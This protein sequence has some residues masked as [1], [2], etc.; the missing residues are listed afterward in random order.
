MP[1]DKPKLLKYDLGCGNNLG[2]GQKGFIGIDITK[3]GTKA[4]I[5]YDLLKFPWLFAKDDSVDEIFCSHF[6]EHI[7]HGN[8]SQDPFFEFFNETYRIL[9]PNAIARFVTPYYTSIR[10]TQDPSHQRSISEATYLYF[11]KDWRKQNGLE[12]YPIKCNFQ[13]IQVGP[14]GLYPD[15]EGRPQEAVQYAMAHYWN[16]A[17]DIMAILKKI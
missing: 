16:V 8:G 6:I 15:W 12:H 5:E 11:M 14:A 1:K 2:G 4:D 10:A 9:K 3:K 7:P 13:I 17:L